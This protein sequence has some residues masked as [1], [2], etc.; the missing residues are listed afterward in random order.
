MVRVK[1]RWV[2]ALCD[3]AAAIPVRKPEERVKRVRGK[4]TAEPSMIQE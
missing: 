3:I 4:P 1:G 2:C